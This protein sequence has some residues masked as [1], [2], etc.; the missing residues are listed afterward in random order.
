MGVLL[1][2]KNVKTRKEHQCYGC[3]NTFQPGTE[4][5]RQCFVCD[6]HA[7]SIYMCQ[8]CLDFCDEHPEEL[9]EDDWEDGYEEGYVRDARYHYERHK[10]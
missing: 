2:D 4:M 10:K 1:S 5:N 8:E 6:H 3:M 9:P 7:Y